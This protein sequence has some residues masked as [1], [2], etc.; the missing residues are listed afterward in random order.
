MNQLNQIYNSFIKQLTA[1][2]QKQN[3][4]IDDFIKHIE[5]LKVQ[6]IKNEIAKMEK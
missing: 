5:G 2:K 4:I 6:E 3:K 1:L